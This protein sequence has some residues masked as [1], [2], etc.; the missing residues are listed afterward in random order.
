MNIFLGMHSDVEKSKVKNNMGVKN[1][2]YSQVIL[3]QN[4]T[5]TKLKQNLEINVF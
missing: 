1:I 2:S 3:Y 5:S 4:H